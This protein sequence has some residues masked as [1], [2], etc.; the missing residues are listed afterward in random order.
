MVK[1]MKSLPKPRR[2]RDIITPNIKKKMQHLGLPI[3]FVLAVVS[4][5]ISIGSVGPRDVDAVEWFAGCK[6]WST[7]LRAK[8]LTVISYEMNDDAVNQ[9]LLTD[10]GL[11]HA[12]SLVFRTKPNG[13][14]HW[15]T[16]CSS[17]VTIDRGMYS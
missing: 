13:V 15:A 4:H 11:L 3:M 10:A 8:G 14:H 17:W 1:S 2:V 16:V 7:A 5:L 12:M 9:N 6:S